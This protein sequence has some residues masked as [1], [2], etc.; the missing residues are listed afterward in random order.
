[1]SVIKNSLSIVIASIIGFPALAEVDLTK[2]HKVDGTH[3]AKC[4]EFYLHKSDIYCSQETLSPGNKTVDSEQYEKVNIVFDDKVWKPIFTEDK[5]D[6][7]TVEYIPASQTANNWKELITTQ[8]VPNVPQN[9]TLKDFVDLEIQFL[10]ADVKKV[11]TKIIED[12]GDSLLFEFTILEPK[13]EQQHEVQY[14]R[15]Q[16]HSLYIIHYVIRSENMSDSVKNAW[17]ERFKASTIKQ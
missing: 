15:K 13:N 14:L 12:K 9:V 1:M 6:I 7:V 16:G 17:I 8:Y 2:L 10:K 3:K 11:D 5:G 4:T